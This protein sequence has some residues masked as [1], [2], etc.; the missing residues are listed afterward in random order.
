MRTLGL[1]MPSWV[2]SV[3]S[4][5][6][7]LFKTKRPFK[8]TKPGWIF[9]L[10]TIGVGAGAIN[11][12]NNLLYLVFGVFLG[13][14]LASGLLSDLSLWRVRVDPLFPESVRAGDPFSIFLQLTNEKKRLPSLSIQV[15]LEGRIGKTGI[16]LKK[17]CPFLS[18]Q[19]RDQVRIEWTAPH[20][21]WF[22]GAFVRLS[23]RFPFGLLEKW[24][25]L[26]T[27]LF[28]QNGFFVT[29][30][31]LPLDFSQLP[32]A[33]AGEDEPSRQ[34]EK[35]DGS[36]LQGIHPFR[37]GDNP[38]RIHWKASAKRVPAYRGDQGAWLVREM[39]KDE[40]EEIVFLCP[41][42]EQSQNLSDEQVEQLASFL[43]SSLVACRRSGYVPKIMAESFVVVHEPAF[44][45]LWDPRRTPSPLLKESMG[46][47]VQRGVVWP[48]R[49]LN[50]LEA[51]RVQ[52]LS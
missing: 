15:S 32:L 19:G 16:V 24:W 29:P 26:K 1:K 36:V 11:T 9:I 52:H 21:G 45:A 20:R 22:E 44:L 31:V 28:N 42:P 37:P 5:S 46:P 18:A 49:S 41:G 12:G 7:S 30:H 4:F 38:R 47:K 27:T 3:V 25:Q 13:L 8:L 48:A 39:N 43:A 17:H 10:Y 33:L 50:V 6:R 35:G 34:W 14:L 51:F 2:R 23:T 40:K